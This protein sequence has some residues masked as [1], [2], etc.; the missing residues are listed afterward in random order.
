MAMN[1]DVINHNSYPDEVTLTNCTFVHVADGTTGTV[2]N[3]NYAEI[4][5]GNSVTI[6]NVNYMT[7]GDNNTNVVISNSNYIIIGN[8][9][10]NVKVGSHS[11]G[12]GLRGTGANSVVITRDTYGIEVTGRWAKF[13]KTKYTQ[14]DGYFNKVDFSKNVL[15]NNSNSNKLN[16]S[17]VINLERT[18]NNDIESAYMELRDRPAF[19]EYNLINRVITVEST[20]PPIVRQS[21]NTGVV[22]DTTLNR[23]I[24]KDELKSE[25]KTQYT[26]VNGQWAEIKK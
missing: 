9:N 20:A 26:K 17:T 5:T 14:V 21:D 24:N 19:Y 3:T 8:S 16:H 12:S 18:N 25:T 7:I 6:T 10:T 15:L 22:L 11:Q 4:G 2:T 13:H 1:Y 23:L